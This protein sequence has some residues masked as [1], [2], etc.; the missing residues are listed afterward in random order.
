VIRQGTLKAA[1]PG[2]GRTLADDDIRA[3]TAY[4]FYLARHKVPDELRK[5]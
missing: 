5:P 2:W 3:V 1:M 4:V